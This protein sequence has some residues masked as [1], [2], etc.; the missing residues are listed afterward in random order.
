MAIATNGVQLVR[1][2]GAVFN[3]Q[4]SASDY[5]EVLAANTTTAA[6]E[7]WANSVVAAEFKNKTT[8][9][10]A[11]TLL[12]NVGLSSVAG[13]E[14]WVVG[15]LNAGGGLA[16]AGQTLLSMLNDYSNMTSDATYG[17]SATT[18]NTKVTASQTLSQKAGTASGTYAAVSTATPATSFTLTSGV[19]TGSSFTGGAGD[20]TF[21]ATGSTLTSG[22]SVSGGTGTDTLSIVTTAQATLGAGVQAAGMEVI[23]LTAT[24][25]AATLAAS[26][27]AGVTTVTNVGSTA[28]VSVSALAAIPVVNVTG[29]SSNTTV[30]MA[31]T[32]IAG[33]TDAVTINLSGVGTTANNSVTVNG[34]ETIN[35]ATTGSASGSTST[36]A[37]FAVTIAA[38]AAQKLAITGTLASSLVSTLTGAT[39]TITGTV[40]DGAAATTL[41]LTAGS[42]AKLSVDMGAG[43]DKLTLSAVA[44]TYTIS[45]GDGTDTLA[46]SGTAT[47]AAAATANITNFEKVSLSGAASFTMAATDVT[48]T[49]DPASATYT[50]LANAG[51]I[52]LQAGGTVTLAN[53]AWTTGTADAIT[54]N[55]GK[56]GVTGTTAQTASVVT[57]NVETITLNGLNST[58]SLTTTSNAFTATSAGVKNIVVTSPIGATLAGGGVLLSNIDASG[59]TGAFTSTATLSTTG[60]T[61]TGGAGADTL[62]GAVGNDSLSGGLGAD[63]ITG[64]FGVD[65]LTGGAGADIFVFGANTGTTAA[66]MVSSATA[67]DTITDFVSGTDRLQITQTNDSFVG[68]VTNIQLGLASMTANN[69][70]F[71]VTGENTLY[72]VATKGTLA[73]TDTIIKMTGVSS[74][75]SADVGTGSQS[76][77]ADLVLGAAGALT[78]FSTANTLTAVTGFNDT[79]RVYTSGNVTNAAVVSGGNGTDTLAFYGVGTTYSADNLVNFTS[80]ENITLNETTVSGGTTTAMYITLD[81]VNAPTNTTTTVNA[82]AVST[83]GIGV[84]G[85][86]INAASTTAQLVITGGSYAAGA[87]GDTLIGGAGNDSIDGGAGN[88]SIVG[89]AGNDTLI[90]GT[91]NDT[92]TAAGTDSVDAGAGDDTL[93]A[94]NAMGSATTASSIELGAGTNT[95][96]LNTGADLTY[97]TVA[98]T[99]GMYQVVVNAGASVTMTPSQYSGAYQVTGTGAESITFATNGTLDFSVASNANAIETVVLSAGTA[100]TGA[101]SLTY[102]PSQTSIVGA[103]GADTFIVTSANAATTLNTGHTLTGGAGTDV[104]NVTGNNAVTVTLGS[105]ITTI[106]TIN[107]A[108]TSTA[109]S[110]TTDAANLT[111]VTQ[112]LAVNA[113]AMTAILTFNGAA[114]TGTTPG[115]YSV[116]GGTGADVIT[117]GAGNDTLIGS[118]GAN[119]MT[120]G[121]GDDTI[122]T[123]TGN[124]TILGGAGNDSITSGTGID[125]VNGGAGAD[126][127]ILGTGGGADAIV[128]ALTDTGTINIATSTTAG[129]LPALGVTISTSGFDNITGFSTAASIQLPTGTGLATTALLR[130]PGAALVSGSQALL[131][132][133]YDA[134][135]QTFIVSNTGTS[136]LYIY[137]ADAANTVEFRAVVLVSY[138]DST[139]IN[140]GAATG[141]TAGA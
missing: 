78:A 97:A 130:S 10:V 22:D 4:L 25:G 19:D 120:G 100:G 133:T 75:A 121:L 81:D 91:G 118:T 38:D 136:S 87:A 56:S 11:K 23:S 119:S 134:T 71:F 99:G 62:T 110:L 66:T 49:T 72:V 54:V 106:E 7:A 16:K 59:V 53:T 24:G 98:S 40:T 37:P 9:D 128:M 46:Y 114:E 123:G 64:G 17:A 103:A 131:V 115:N 42:S 122:T 137:D 20:D 79:V 15:Q 88:D 63:S 92:I 27:I 31:D 104:I 58:A 3:Q 50:S 69:Q 141:L 21:N 113:S 29:T 12:T 101:N 43:D 117:G 26:G 1:L 6:L 109:V 47:V 80:F 85:A 32:V 105:G 74:L 90:G 94:T 52:N 138:L 2:A 102:G 41:A 60:A 61:I 51:T 126:T 34:V 107:F 108:N 125:S 28:D 76:G 67:T 5:S 73:N 129:T 140:S 112:T 95:L 135:A 33:T 124:D 68:N 14:N 44:A 139:S 39:G 35:V 83:I 8:T 55:V 111:A 84:D 86:A 48:Y 132:G 93:I 89:G 18:F 70:S 77:G 30:A 96:Q 36:T 127:I 57:T 116:T 82:S 65:V 45:G 13:L